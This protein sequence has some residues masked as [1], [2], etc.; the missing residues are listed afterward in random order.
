[1]VLATTAFWMLYLKNDLACGDGLRTS[2]P[3]LPGVEL[4]SAGT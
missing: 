4:L 1:M 3:L 2:V